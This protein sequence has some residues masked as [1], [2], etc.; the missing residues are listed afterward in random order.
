M[1]LNVDMSSNFYF[2]YSYDLTNTMQHNLARPKR[3]LNSGTTGV[4]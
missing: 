3:L 1:F 2:S 4:F